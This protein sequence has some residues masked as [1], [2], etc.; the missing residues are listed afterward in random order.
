VTIDTPYPRD[1]GLR[2]SPE[3]NDYCRTV[4]ARLAAAMSG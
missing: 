3:Y 4:S 1:D 2:T